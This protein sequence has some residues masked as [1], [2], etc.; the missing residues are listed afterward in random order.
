VGADQL[1]GLPGYPFGND[2]GRGGR[3]HPTVLA[4]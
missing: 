2:G 3:A 1:P 4:G